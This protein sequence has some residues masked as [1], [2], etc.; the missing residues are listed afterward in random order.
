MR[1]RLALI[2]LLPVFA[3]AQE[4]RFLKA[5]VAKLRA[6]DPSVEGDLLPGERLAQ[7]CLRPEQST[8]TAI[9]PK[10]LI[11]EWLF[12]ASLFK[13]RDVTALSQDVRQ[14]Y[15]VR[16]WELTESAESSLDRAVVKGFDRYYRGS[17][18]NRASAA[19]K[20]LNNDLAGASLSKDAWQVLNWLGVEIAVRLQDPEKC[21]M[22]SKW[23]DTQ[24]ALDDRAI[25][26][27]TLAALYAGQ[28]QEAKTRAELLSK[29]GPFLARLSVP[30]QQDPSSF[31]YVGA[32]SALNQ[33]LPTDPALPGRSEYSI[34]V[35]RASLKEVKGPADQVDRLRTQIG[36]GWKEFG[37]YEKPI[38]R[39]GALG[40]WLKPGT[41]ATPLC[42]PITA[43]R[44]HLEGE[45][46]LPDGTRLSEILD[47][48]P[49]E[50][51][52]DSWKGTM[53]TSRIPAQ[54]SPVIVTFNVQ[55]AFNIK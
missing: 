7:Y 50:G 52:P 1:H 46:T 49:M 36:E 21:R 35:H 22:A 2:L 34:L 5:S 55:M 25:A 3:Q 44:M 51:Q 23:F 33:F 4:L 39:V 42:G 16:S 26:Y 13:T 11:A 53:S 20:Q 30:S 43:N 48:T 8:I 28:W 27:G 40:E 47:L 6:N 15:L 17:D 31:N 32:L 41:V 12:R 10:L 37:P 24:P 9:E 19:A 38:L 29:K 54:G 45:A 14:K 18:P